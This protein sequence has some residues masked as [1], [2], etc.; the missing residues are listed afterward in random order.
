[1]GLGDELYHHGIEGQRWGKRNGPPYPLNSSARS[2]AERKAS[3][4]AA[5]DAKKQQY[6]K[7]LLADAFVTLKSDIKKDSNNKLS[8]TIQFEGSKNTTTATDNRK[9]T[10][11]SNFVSS[12]HDFGKNTDYIKGEILLM[13]DDLDVIEEDLIHCKRVSFEDNS[14]CNI[15]YYTPKKT[16]TV[17]TTPYTFDW[18]VKDRR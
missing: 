7:N 16:I 17:E 2:F 6:W 3:K 13:A 15:E 9:F 10:N 5:K 14:V 8:T 11:P 4:K 18:N 1:M 12:L